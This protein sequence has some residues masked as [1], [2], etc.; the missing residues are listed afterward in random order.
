MNQIKSFKDLGAWHISHEVVIMIY[1]VTKQFPDSEKFIL[2]NQ[3]RRS[4]I[5]VTS[6]IS[7]GFSRRSIKEKIQ[8]Y[9]IAAASSSEL[10]SQLITARDVDYLSRELFQNIEQKLLESQRVLGGLIRSTKARL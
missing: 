10:Y 2:T 4:A 3:M 8:F 5:S 7:E 1:Q 9:S 6:N